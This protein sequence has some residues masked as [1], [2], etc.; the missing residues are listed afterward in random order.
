MNV[1][2]EPAPPFPAQKQ[3]KPGIEEDMQPRPKYEALLYKLMVH[4]DRG[5]DG[6]FDS[7]HERGK[8]EVTK[9]IGVPVH[10]DRG[11]YHVYFLR[12]R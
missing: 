2:N 12:C 6:V 7:H 9:P 3:P 1:R 10:D 11:H 4:G 8:L 5:K